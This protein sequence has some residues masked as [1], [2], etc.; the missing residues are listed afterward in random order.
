MCEL[1]QVLQSGVY[2]QIPKSRVYLVYMHVHS[3]SKEEKQKGGRR[4]SEI[5]TSVQVQRISNLLKITHLKRQNQ[6]LNKGSLALELPPYVLE[7][8]ITLCY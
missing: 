1:K 7:N 2:M 8:R 4:L 5:S 3:R 6:D